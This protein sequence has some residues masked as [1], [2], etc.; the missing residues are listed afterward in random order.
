[1]IGVESHCWTLTNS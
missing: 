1:M